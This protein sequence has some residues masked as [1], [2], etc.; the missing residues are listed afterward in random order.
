MIKPKRKEKKM[1]KINKEN[2]FIST[3]GVFDLIS[4][5]EFNLIE[6]EYE[7][8]YISSFSRYWVSKDNKKLIRMSNHWSNN[9]DNIRSCYWFLKSANIKE[10][11]NYFGIIEF[12]N[13]LNLSDLYQLDLIERIKNIYKIKNLIK[14]TSE[15]LKSYDFNTALKLKDNLEE[16]GHLNQEKHIKMYE[17]IKI[18]KINELKRF[19]KQIKDLGKI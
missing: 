19:K 17:E 13:L 3:K 7:L 8:N 1:K 2:Y 18:N 10:N 6:N 14:L 11:K 15:E 9:C 4:K 5:E 12:D 16:Y